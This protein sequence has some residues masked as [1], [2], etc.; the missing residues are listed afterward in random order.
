MAFFARTTD[1]AA[2][3]LY[4]NCALKCGAFVELLLAAN[5]REFREILVPFENSLLLATS[6]DTWRVVG[7]QL[8][9]NA[10]LRRQFRWP[11]HVIHFS[12]HWHCLSPGR[13][14][15]ALTY[16]VNNISLFFF[17]FGF[18]RHLGLRGMVVDPRS[19]VRPVSFLARS[20]SHSL[21]VSSAHILP[22]YFRSPSLPFSMYLFRHHSPHL[23]MSAIAKTDGFCFKRFL[24]QH[25]HQLM[26]HCLV[27]LS[28]HQIFIIYL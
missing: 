12:Y 3:T 21:H 16:P 8:V 10:E 23:I 17:V 13:S 22:S 26:N 28:T 18:S 25:I 19:P 27:H 1:F 24:S 11:L 6:R 20:P 2:K 14:L 9:N 5:D 7:V 15:V 4:Y